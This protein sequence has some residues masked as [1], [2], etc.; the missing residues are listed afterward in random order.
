MKNF[1]KLYYKKI[2][3]GSETILFLHG[4]G[5][6]SSS[7][8]YQVEHFKHRYQI[9]VPD[10]RGHGQSSFFDDYSFELCADDL[11]FLLKSLGIKK[12]HLCGFSLGGM[13]TF[14]FAIKYPNML[15]SLCI[16][17]CVASFRLD[18]FKIKFLYLLR[19]V[20]ARIVPMPLFAYFMAIK[21]FPYK[22]DKEL[23]VKMIKYADFVNKEGYIKAIDAMQDWNVQNKVLDIEVKTIF[24]GSEFDYKVFDGK[25]DLSKKMKN[26]RYV[27]IKGAHHFII[28]EFAQEFNRVYEEFLN[29][30]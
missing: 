23:R 18:S 20:I 17:N 21:L 30:L 26:A 11:Y 27:E 4:L 8:Q 10:L 3:T 16:A 24:I 29:S 5:V 9:L 14:E 6:T 1:K 19:R 13:V 2:G 15:H 25:S 7:W 12:V 22:K 28:W